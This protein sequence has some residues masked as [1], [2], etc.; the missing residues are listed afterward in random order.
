MPSKRRRRRRSRRRRTNPARALLILA[1]VAVVVVGAF[2]GLHKYEQSRYH[3]NRGETSEYFYEDTQIEVDGVEYKSKRDLTSILLEGVTGSEDSGEKVEM[4]IL[5]LLDHKQQTIRWMQLDPHTVLASGGILRDALPDEGDDRERAKAVMETVADLLGTKIELYLSLDLDRMGV[6]NHALNG[7][8]LTLSGDY[9]AYDPAMTAGATLTLSDAQAELYMNPS[10][11]LADDT[12]AA[13]MQ[14]QQQFLLAALKALEREA[15][16][17]TDVLNRFYDELGEIM[18]T[19]V[20]P[21]RMLN[22]AARARAYAIAQPE[23][24]PGAE[25]VSA[26]GAKR[27]ELDSAQI[28]SWVLEVFYNRKQ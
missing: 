24:L 19:N 7:I 20:R 27:Y 8:E 3:T 21:A 17:D 13:R 14:R 28:Q 10:V 9:S 5:F 12:C 11:S 4:L 25:S 26:D 16:K 18:V 23:L 15:K 22:E 2:V 6:L 1:L